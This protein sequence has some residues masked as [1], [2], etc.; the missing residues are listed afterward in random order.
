MKTFCVC[1]KRKDYIGLYS[2]IRN[3]GLEDISDGR[4]YS[5]NDLVKTDTNN[6]KD[7]KKICCIGMGKTI[8]LDPYDCFMLSVGTGKT[9]EQLSDNNIELNVVDGCILPNIR[10][11]SYTHLTL[12]TKRIV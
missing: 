3:V 10:T 5:E 4:L 6:C 9:F 2:M 1:V 12:P 8:V 11:V 7:C